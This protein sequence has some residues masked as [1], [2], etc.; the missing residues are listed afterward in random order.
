MHLPW[1]VNLVQ[2]TAGY[3]PATA[4]EALLHTYL[5]EQEA[6]AVATFAQNW[7]ALARSASERPEAGGNN[8][9][10]CGTGTSHRRS[11]SNSSNGSHTSTTSTTTTATTDTSNTSSSR[12]RNDTAPQTTDTTALRQTHL[13]PQPATGPTEQAPT[14]GD[15]DPHHL[16]NR[17]MSR[18]L[19]QL[20]D[21]NIVEALRHKVFM[22]T[23]PPPFLRGRVRAALHFAL[24]MICTARTELE[25]TRAWKLWL[26]LPRMLLHRPQGTRTIPKPE[27]RERIAAF[28]QGNWPELLAA[29]HAC[30]PQDTHA[31]GRTATTNNERRLERARHLVHQ[32][33]L[34]A[35][36]QALTAVG[37]APGTETT[38]AQLQDP[39]RRP[40]QPYQAI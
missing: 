27:W 25:S 37:L 9:T 19:H 23:T 32:G 16:D 35:A 13:A 30:A 39:Q 17:Q 10:N 2:Q 12:A 21:V 36:R 14:A 11:P 34:S 26:P 6:S 33:E 7:A 28:Q 15:T 5:G 40:Q 31:D 20:D 1:A 18:A 8:T 29:A 4:Q 22:F 3:I 38:L 24:E